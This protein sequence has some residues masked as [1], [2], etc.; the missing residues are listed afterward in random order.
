MIKEKT[1]WAEQSHTR[2]FLK[3][4]LLFP[5]SSNSCIT[6]LTFC[7]E[8][9]FYQILSS[10]RPRCAK[11]LFQIFLTFYIQ[12]VLRNKMNKKYSK[13]KITECLSILTHAA[14]ITKIWPVCDKPWTRTWAK[15]L[16]CLSLLF[17]SSNLLARSLLPVAAFAP[18]PWKPSRFR[19][20]RLCVLKN[21]TDR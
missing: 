15:Y 10:Q 17:P 11:G 7:F 21:V 9:L 5:P 12:V 14:H 3:D 16:A 1:S 2:N 6:Y 13:H 19:R 18:S 20:H 8:V 4:F